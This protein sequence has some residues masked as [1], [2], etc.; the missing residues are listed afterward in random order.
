MAKRKK[1]RTLGCPCTLQGADD[2]EGALTPTPTGLGQLEVLRQRSQAIREEV[3]KHPAVYVLAGVAAVAGLGFVGWLI[4]RWLKPR[5]EA[6]DGVYWHYEQ[7]GQRRAQ[8]CVVVR[9]GSDAGGRFYELAC[10]SEAVPRKFYES[11]EPV[12]R[13][14]TL[15]P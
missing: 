7:G 9:V 10:G 6:G 1:I 5:F 8:A 13:E 14:L 11:N 15:T 4:W 3:G 2:G 12:M